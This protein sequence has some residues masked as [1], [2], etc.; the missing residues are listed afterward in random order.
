MKPCGCPIKYD[1]L[2]TYD[3]KRLGVL[4]ETI[5]IQTSVV[6]YS[7]DIKTDMRDGLVLLALDVDISDHPIKAELFKSG[8]L[9]LYPGFVWDFGT[10]AVDTP[11]VVRA[12]LAHDVLCEMVNKKLLPKKCRKVADKDYY[13]A[14]RKYG[15]NPIRAWWQY[16][17]VRL[18]GIV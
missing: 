2:F 5:D 10:G 6:G 17:A 14:L 8:T 3:G 9:T 4:L 11:D 16:M 7:A 18:A 15:M 1:L 12:S 13:N